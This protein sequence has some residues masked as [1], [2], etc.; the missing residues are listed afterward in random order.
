MLPVHS[1]RPKEHFV[2]GW[3]VVQQRSGNDPDPGRR[4]A[5]GG[6]SSRK[7]TSSLGMTWALRTRNSVWLDLFDDDGG[8]AKQPG[9][10]RRALL[11]AV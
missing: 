2:R 6:C 5:A 9:R 10:S 3:R 1:R 4:A 8:I 7:I 11:S